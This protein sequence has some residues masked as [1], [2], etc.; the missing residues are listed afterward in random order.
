MNKIEK[1]KLLLLKELDDVGCK[2]CRWSTCSIGCDS[3][4]GLSDSFAEKLAKS[5]VELDREDRSDTIPAPLLSAE[6]A[7]LCE[8]NK[9]M[10]DE[11]KRA[12]ERM[13]SAIVDTKL[14][15]IEID[16]ETEGIELIRFNIE[17]ERTVESE[18]IAGGNDAEALSELIGKMCRALREVIDKANESIEK[19]RRA[20]LRPVE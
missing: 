6:N 5:I 7:E 17:I 1:V 2:T 16:R 3:L 10:K 14:G 12:I 19:L 20:S 13:I 9:T 15:T 4:W 11:N 18:R 8:G